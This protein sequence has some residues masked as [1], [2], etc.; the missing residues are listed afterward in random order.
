MAEGVLGLHLPVPSQLGIHLGFSEELLL[1]I[2]SEQVTSGVPTTADPWGSP[3]PGASKGG[4]CVR[5]P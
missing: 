2:G 4:A 1:S 3:G 5:A